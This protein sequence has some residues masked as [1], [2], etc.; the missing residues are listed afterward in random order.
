MIPHA[1]L[2]KVR[3]ALELYGPN[4]IISAFHVP[5]WMRLMKSLF[6]GTAI[7]LWI[8]IILCFVN[9]SIAVKKNYDRLV[10]RHNRKPM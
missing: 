8:G 3:A 2:S 1:F 5:A 6:G 7:I 10:C 9:F 4:N